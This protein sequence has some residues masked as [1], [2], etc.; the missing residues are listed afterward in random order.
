MNLVKVL[1]KHK[2]GKIEKNVSLKKYTTYKVG[3]TA[4]II[5]F[6]KNVDKLIELLK[7]LKEYNIEYKILGNGSNLIFSDKPYKKVLIKLNELNSCEIEDTVI[8]VGST[9]YSTGPHAHFEVRVNGQPVNPLQYINV[10]GQEKTE[11]E[12]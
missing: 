4:D 6:P 5:V 8:K 3:G 11:V 9:G 2:I 12:K 1:E 10:P 7:I